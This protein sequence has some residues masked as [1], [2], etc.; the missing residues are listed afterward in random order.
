MIL[1]MIKKNDKNYKFMK[2]CFQKIM[3]RITAN[4]ATEAVKNEEAE[5]QL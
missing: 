4:K 5:I 3:A 2:L 1:K